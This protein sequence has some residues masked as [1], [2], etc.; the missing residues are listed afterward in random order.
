MRYV[1][2]YGAIA[3]AITIAAISS[4]FVFE[5]LNHL[6]NEW[7]GYLVMLVALSLIFAGI[8]RYRDVECGGIIGFGRALLLG[9]GIAIVAGL[10]YVIGWEG[11]LVT[12]D[13]N[14]I[15]T[16]T[17][18]VLADMRASGASTAEMPRPSAKW[19]GRSSFT[20]TRSRVCRSPFSSSFRSG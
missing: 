4:S 15:E 14:F 10:I 5:D 12:T 18:G 2:I 11:Y 3:G 16:Y 7:F 20:R 13:G 1:L 8:K 19:R 17:A 6:Q 9:T